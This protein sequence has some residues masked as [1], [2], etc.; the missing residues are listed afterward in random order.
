MHSTPLLMNMATLWKPL[1][2][3][4]PP[5]TAKLKDHTERL[6]NESDAYFGMLVLGS[7]FGPMPFFMLFGYTT[8]LITP[9]LNHTPYQAYTHRIP[10]LDNVIT[11]G[12]KIIAKKAKKRP[13][14]LDPNTYNGIFLGYRATEDLIRY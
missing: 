12:A 6:R 14:A 1:A 10:T 4:H 2:L 8:A 9:P 3:M 13:T 7:N 11:F 5:W